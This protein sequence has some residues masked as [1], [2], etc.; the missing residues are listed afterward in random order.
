[1]NGITAETKAFSPDFL[2]IGAQKCGTTALQ[3]FLNEHPMV[4]RSEKEIHY[5]DMNFDKEE[6]WYKTQIGAGI[7]PGLLLGDK[8]PYYLFHPLVPQRVAS[9]YPDT[10]IIIILRNPIDRAYSHYWHNV[11]N[12]RE[13]LTFEEALNAEASRLQGEKDKLLQDPSYNSMNY[14]NFSYI[15]RGYYAEQIKIWRNYFPNEQIFILF[16]KDLKTKPDIVMNEVFQFL[17]IP[18]KSGYQQYVQ[19]SVK[20]KPMNPETRRWLIDLYRPYN[21]QLKELLGI[22]LNWDK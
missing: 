18:S 12:F 7:K 14:K 20:Y 9:L 11:F 16:T 19:R 8:S 4:Q 5:F 6:S 22:D 21:R 17:G 1:M 15:A 2:I 10:K 3:N 13:S